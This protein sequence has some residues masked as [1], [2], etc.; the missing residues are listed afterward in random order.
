[1]D[2]KSCLF[3]ESHEWVEASGDVRRVGISDHAQQM[4]GD[5]VFVE[6]PEVGRMLT[7]GDEF[8]VVES[9]KAAASIYAPCSGEVVEVNDALEG[10]PE[11]INRSPYESG[12]LVK[13]RPSNWDGEKA[14]LLDHD[15]YQRKLEEE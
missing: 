4:L 8:M 11:T 12:W 14:S 6:M 5:I 10:A 3:L 13:I 9:P 2:P 1:M 15:A 7:K